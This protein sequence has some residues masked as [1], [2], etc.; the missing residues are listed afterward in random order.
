M[1]LEIS[2]RRFSLFAPFAQFGG[3][4]SPP[5]GMKPRIHWVGDKEAKE[6]KPQADGPRGER[7]QKKGPRGYRDLASVTLGEVHDAY[8]HFKNQ[9]VVSSAPGWLAP[10]TFCMLHLAPKYGVARPP[11]LFGRVKTCY[12]RDGY[13]QNVQEFEL[14][15]P[16]KK[17]APDLLHLRA[18]DVLQTA[19]KPLQSFFVRVRVL[20]SA[21]DLAELSGRAELFLQ[22]GFAPEFHE[23][24]I[25][26]LQ[27]DERNRSAQSWIY[28]IGSRWFA[29][30]PDSVQVEVREKI[31]KLLHWKKLVFNYHPEHL[32]REVRTLNR[33]L[34]LKAGFT[35]EFLLEPETPEQVAEIVSSKFEKLFERPWGKLK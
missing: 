18:K 5:S 4:E 32:P 9:L 13:L 19:E 31:G 20:A 25:D 2:L 23:G 34:G 1:T 6:Q 16:H 14:A 35:K 11:A 27:A 7:P 17:H 8:N 28:V 22:R 26:L 29:D 33:E 21:Q 3:E 12:P 24:V 30:A 15:L 10:N